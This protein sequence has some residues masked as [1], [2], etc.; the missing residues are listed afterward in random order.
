MTN[1]YT[2]DTHFGDENIVKFSKRPFNSVAHMARVLIASMRQLVGPEEDL[3]IVGDF[4]LDER[5]KNQSYLDEILSQLPGARKQL[6]VGNHDGPLTQALS[7]D[8]VSHLAEVRGGPNNQA[9]AL[10]LSFA[11]N[12]CLFREAHV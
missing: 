12:L 2:S 10:P 11:P 7:W 1:W 6:V 8:G 4:A 9:H 5:S 3:W